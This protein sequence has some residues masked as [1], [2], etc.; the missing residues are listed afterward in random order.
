MEGGARLVAQELRD[1]GVVAEK[2]MEVN[3]C[4]S[5][6]TELRDEY[7]EKSN[8]SVSVLI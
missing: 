2:T 7:A 4:R 3:P 8:K 5:I 1:T 6:R